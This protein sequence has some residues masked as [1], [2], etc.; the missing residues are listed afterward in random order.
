MNLGIY[1]HIPFCVSKCD[2][3]NFY[4]ITKLD[5]VNDY[6]LALVKEIKRESKNYKDYSID[7]IFI[8]GGTPSILPTGAISSIVN[9]IKKHYNVNSD[10]EISIESNPN[11]ITYQN[12]TE[13]FNCGINRVSVGLQST[14]DRLLKKIGRAHTFSDFLVAV[15]NLKKVGFKNINADIML[16]LPTQKQGDVKNTLRHC[17]RS[18]ITHLSAYT[19]ILEEDTPLYKKI[20][21]NQIK[22]VSEQKTLGMFSYVLKHTKLN[23]YNRYEV[24][25]FAL[26]GFEC[27]H[28]LNCWNMCDYVGFGCAAHSFVNSTRFCNVSNVAGYIDAISKSKSVIETKEKITNNELV[29]ES[30]MLGLRTVKGLDLQKLFDKFKY[31]LLKNK[32][33]QIEKLVSLGLIEIKDNFLFAT[34]KGFYVLNQIIVELVD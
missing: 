7:T 3:C 8:G 29:E 10:C 19:L 2:Y 26:N 18:G 21:L 34:E 14:S 13:W 31:D 1:V 24:S 15:D 27:K 23:G 32:K 30:I 22:P 17:F 25:N 11:S 6:V 9:T 16:G 12:A 5:L 28:N 4:S 33:S 20:E